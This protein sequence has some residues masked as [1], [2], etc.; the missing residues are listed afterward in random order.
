M[1]SLI[2]DILFSMNAM[3]DPGV[4]IKHH[5]SCIIH[6]YNFVLVYICPLALLLPMKL[7]GVQF[8]FLLSMAKM[9]HDVQ[10]NVQK[11]PKWNKNSKAT[12]ESGVRASTCFGKISEF[13][14]TFVNFVVLFVWLL[15][16]LYNF[17][18]PPLGNKLFVY[19]TW[20]SI[21]LL[22]NAH[23]I[24]FSSLAHPGKEKNNIWSHDLN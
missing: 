20:V 1:Q 6:V 10:Q 11:S 23:T 2:C 12:V 4:S 15:C 17:I 16:F 24:V 18:S 19:C 5:C 21:F 8:T 3:S 14:T 13:S 7:F 9:W 22:E